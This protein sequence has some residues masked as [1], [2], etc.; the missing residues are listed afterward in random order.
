MVATLQ[1]PTYTHLFAVATLDGR[2]GHYCECHFQRKKLWLGRL[3][4]PSD[5]QLTNREAR[6]WT[7]EGWHLNP[8]SSTDP[9]NCSS[10]TNQPTNMLILLVRLEE[11]CK[12]VPYS[13]VRSKGLSN[14]TIPPLTPGS[15]ALLLLVI[16]TWNPLLNHQNQ[17]QILCFPTQSKD[18]NRPESQPSKISH[19]RIFF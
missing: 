14:I 3:T 19:L 13:P 6:I 1:T 15:S 11:I 17:S 7:L 8:G 2:D 4:L 5:S 12:E 16:P 9:E 10:K 18:A